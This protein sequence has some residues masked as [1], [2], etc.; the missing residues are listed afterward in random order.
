MSFGFSVG[1]FIAGAKLI[2]D[3]ITALNGAPELEHRGLELELYGLERALDELGHLE[4]EFGQEADVDSVKEAALLCRYPLEEFREKLNRYRVWSQ[5]GERNRMQVLQGLGRKVQWTLSM[6]DEIQRLR[7]Y[8]AAHTV[9]PQLQNIAG[10]A[11]KVLLSNLQILAYVTDRKSP[12]VDSKYTWFQQPLRFEDAVGRVVPIPVEYGWSTAE[13]VV[14]GQFS[15]GPGH[16]KVFAGEYEIFYTEDS[17]KLVT[18]DTWQL[19]RP[20]TYITMAMVIGKYVEIPENLCPK[21]GC[22]SRDFVK[23][24]AGGSTC[25]RCHTWF[26]KAQKSLQRPFRLLQAE[27][28]SEYPI[29]KIGD[30]KDIQNETSGE[31]SCIFKIIREERKWFKNVRVF[32]TDLSVADRI[33][34]HQKIFKVLTGISSVTSTITTLGDQTAHGS[35]TLATTKWYPQTNTGPSHV[36][37]DEIWSHLMAILLEEMGLQELPEDFGE[38]ERFYEIGMD[39]LMALFISARFREETDILLSSSVFWEYPT[40]R[41]LRTFLRAEWNIGGRLVGSS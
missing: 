26:G 8:I 2:K 4:P 18:K 28:L 40:L 19:L 36:V 30:S 11:G 39:S 41:E 21:L 3:I 27:A 23:V 10:I 20:G 1:D 25:S 15:S 12:R 16:D 6:P 17:S 35:L 37:G 13:A 14:R 9:I 32:L 38:D 7:A 31:S 34:E 5:G 29:S 24:Q 22:A 33:L